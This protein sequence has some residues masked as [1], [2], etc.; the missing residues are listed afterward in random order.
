MASRAAIDHVPATPAASAGTR[1]R[2]LSAAGARGWLACH[3]ALLPVL[4]VSALLDIVALGQNGYANAFYSA[5]VKSMLRSWHNFFFVSFDPQGFISIDKPP[6]ALWLQAASAKVLGFTPLALLLPEALAGVATVAVLYFAML[7]PFGRPAALTGAGTLAIFPAFVAVA[8]D[9]GPDPLMILLMTLACLAALRAIRTGG[10]RALL[11]CAVAVALAFN[12]KTLAAVLVL[13]PIV[14]AYVLCAPGPLRGRI[15]RLAVAGA[16]TAALSLSWITAVDLTPASQRPWVGGSTGNSELGLTFAYNGLGRLDGE[17]GAEGEIPYRPGA[18]VLGAQP[19]TAA[20]AM[21]APADYHPLAGGAPTEIRSEPGPAGPL[22]LCDAELGGQGGWVLPIALCALLAEAAILLARLRRG[23][24]SRREERLAGIVVLGG[25]FAIEALV[26]SFAGGIVHPYY[27][28]ALAPGAAALTGAGA[29][30]LAARA[31]ERSPLALLLAAG[32]A[33]TLAAQV[34]LLERDGY[35]S[36]LAPLLIAGCAL[37][38]AAALLQPRVLARPSPRLPRGLRLA[39]PHVAGDSARTSPQGRTPAAARVL[40][41][42]RGRATAVAL[43][44]AL[45]AIVPTAYSITTWLAPVQG[46]FPAA[47]PRAAAGVGG[48]GLEGEDRHLLPALARYVDE[49][50]PGSRFAV[51]TVASVAAAPLILMG[52]PATAIAGYGGTDPALDGRGLARMVERGE[53][54][55]VLLGGPYSERGGNRATQAV[56]RVCPQVPARAWGGPPLTPYSFVLFDCS[57]RARALAR[58]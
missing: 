32:V 56:L 37:A 35:L 7:R 19:S 40:A 22:R 50:S 5:G 38:L 26:L 52:T 21:P 14:L 17:E 16:V 23:R 44:V 25:W 58:S 33:A 28:S 55:Y 29:A 18:T 53:A 42:V 10:W 4:A 30:L 27:V 11:G 46:T 3:A 2:G 51:L 45:L 57:G 48:I 15:G 6:L 47:G 36:W 9:N 13:P 31:R 49:H 43:A 34:V 1:A 20:G 41:R 8:R 12:T 24:S 54:R 39:H